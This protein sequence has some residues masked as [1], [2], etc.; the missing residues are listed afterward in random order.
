MESQYQII[1][2]RDLGIDIHEFTI[3]GE[4]IAVNEAS[5]NDVWMIQENKITITPIYNSLYSHSH[6]EY[7]LSIKLYSFYYHFGQIQN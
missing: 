5:D 3:G 6:F 7:L 1:L 4:P 2:K